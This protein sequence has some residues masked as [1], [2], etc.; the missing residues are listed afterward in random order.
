MSINRSKTCFS[1]KAKLHHHTCEL[2]QNPPE[3]H[4]NMVS[5][6]SGKK[7]VTFKEIPEILQPKK[8]VLIT[9]RLVGPRGL[10]DNFVLDP[11]D[12][13][14]V[15]AYHIYQDEAVV[16]VQ[17][18]LNGYDP[19]SVYLSAHVIDQQLLVIRGHRK[20]HGADMVDSSKNPLVFERRFKMLS[21]RCQMDQ[22]ISKLTKEVDGTLVLTVTT[23][24]V[25]W[26][27]KQAIT[28]GFARKV[29]MR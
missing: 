27:Q 5:S 19:N 9:T 14:K 8:D 24:K 17:L 13:V 2:L 7:Q 23:P 29:P 28:N 25:I 1:N 4:H 18:K 16:E 20:T 21:D 10:M 26:R 12:K 15:I 6:V 11:P 22:S 3:E